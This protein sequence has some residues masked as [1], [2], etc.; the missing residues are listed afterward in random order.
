LPVIEVLLRHGER[1]VRVPA[2]VD[3]GADVSAF[4]INHAL[5][6]GPD[7]AAAVHVPAVGAG[8]TEIDCLSWPG[9]ELQFEQERFPFVGRF[10]D[11]PSG[12][13]RVNLLGR[14]D[15]FQRYIIQF[16][17]A[18]GLLGI[19]VSPDFPR[20]TPASGLTVQ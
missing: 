13:P 6:L 11:F 20:D 14:Q 10:I 1:S 12:S 16:W 18:A 8:G 17:D 3:S 15:F 19:D 2:L 4:D 9:L 5:E 7:R